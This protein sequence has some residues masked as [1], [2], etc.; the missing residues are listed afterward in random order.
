MSNLFLYSGVYCYNRVSRW[1]RRHN[2]FSYSKVFFPI[3]LNNQHWV[4]IVWIV[5][6]STLIF[7][8]SMHGSG[9]LSLDVIRKWILDEAVDK[10]ITIDLSYDSFVLVNTNY[11]MPVQ[12]NG[13][14]CGMFVVI[15]IDFM[16]DSLEL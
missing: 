5:E 9:H 3:N 12:N 10:G 15:G 1:T 4:F 11:M 2:V 8:D 7:N 16:S 13:L 14:D 6:T